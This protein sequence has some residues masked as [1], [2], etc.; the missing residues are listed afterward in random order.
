MKKTLVV[1]VV[2]GGLLVGMAVGASAQPS[3]AWIPGFASLLI[4][5]LGQLLN[6][7]VSKAILHLG[8]DVAINVAGYYAAVFLPLGYYGYPVWGLAH[9]AW[10]L[11]SGYDAYTVARQR[12]FSL[13]F[14]DDGLTLSYRF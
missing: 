4:P 9:L 7:E 10:A 1:L 12:G 13:G 5:G 8:V 6:D 2:V 3:E 11:Y 14:T